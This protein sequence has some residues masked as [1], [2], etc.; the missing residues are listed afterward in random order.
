MFAMAARFDCTYEFGNYG[1]AP[2]FRDVAETILN[3]EQ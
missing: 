3:G 2:F 1:A